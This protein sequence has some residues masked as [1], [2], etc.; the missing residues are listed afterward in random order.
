MYELIHNKLFATSEY[1]SVYA[2]AGKDY[3]KVNNICT[4]E[5]SN[6]KFSTIEDTHELC[7]SGRSKGR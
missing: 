1:Y 7:N 5:I 3:N 6:I 4:F 2:L